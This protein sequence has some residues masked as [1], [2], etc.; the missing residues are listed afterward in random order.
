MHGESD[1]TTTI[2]NLTSIFPN[3]PA[4]KNENPAVGQE[5]LA[6]SKGHCMQ[7]SFLFSNS[8]LH[9]YAI[10]EKNVQKLKETFYTFKI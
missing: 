6:V 5:V 3:I 2:M 7:N 10:I 8:E 1:V 9:I 4:F